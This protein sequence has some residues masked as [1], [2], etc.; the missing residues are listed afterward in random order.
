VD[1][2][3]ALV[4]FAIL[5]PMWVLTARRRPA[6]LAVSEADQEVA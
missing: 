1:I 2:T 5:I 4:S 6:L 3:L